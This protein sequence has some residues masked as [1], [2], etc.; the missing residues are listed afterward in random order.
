MG[1]SNREGRPTRRIRRNE[2]VTIQ[3]TPADPPSVLLP[4]AQTG[5]PIPYILGRQ[6]IFSPN[7]IWYGNLKPRYKITRETK[8]EEIEHG[9]WHLN[10][11]IIEIITI[12]TIVITKTV[13]GYTIDMQLGLCL[14]PDV[15][16][17][18]IYEDNKL[19][20]SGDV[21]PDPT[22]L[23]VLGTSFDEGEEEGEQ[24]PL[25]CTF[26]GGAFNQAPDP[27]L[28]TKITTGVPG[29]VG[30]AHFIV[31]NIDITKGVRNLSFE[32]ERH[33]DPLALTDS[34]NLIDRDLNVAS[35]LADILTNDWGGVGL[36]ISSLDQASFIEAAQTLA[37]E[38]NG[39]SIYMQTEAT[40]DEP[41]GVLQDQAD[42]VLY[43]NPETGK[44]VFKLI[45]STNYEDLTEPS[46]DKNNVREVRDFNKGSWVGVY[47]Q[48]RG[49]YTNRDGNYAPGA[50]VAQALTVETTLGKSKQSATIDYPAVMKNTLAAQLV[51]RDLSEY[52]VPLPTA[53]MEADRGASRL[54][55]G[56]G[57][58]INWPEHGLADFKAIVWKRRDTPR[59]SNRAVVEFDQ[60]IKPVTTAIFTPGDDGL[61]DPLDPNPH[62]P[63]S[64]R[65]ITA[66]TYVLRNSGISVN[67]SVAL[68]RGF[69]LVLAEAYGAPQK[70]FDGYIANMPGQ[71]KPVRVVTKGSYATVGQIMAPIDRFDGVTTGELATIDIEGVTRDAWLSDIGED[72][73]RSGRL[74]MW[75]NNE[76]LS[77]E[78]VE[79]LGAGVWRL[80]NVHRGL[81]DT[82]AQDH[83]T[84]DDV[85]IIGNNYDYLAKSNHVVPPSYTPSWRLVGNAVEKPGMIADSLISTAWAPDDRADLPARPHNFKINGQPRSA[86]PLNLNAIVSPD[87]E[88]TWATRNRASFAVALQLDA[89]EDGERTN[90]GIAQ[91][92]RL[93]LEDRLGVIFD[94]GVTENDDNYNAMEFVIPNDAAEGIGQM[95]VQAE[96][97]F[98]VSRY[99]DVL[100]V[101]IIHP[102]FNEVTEDDERIVT[103]DGDYIITD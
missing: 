5:I 95:W 88:A 27:Y 82:V 86:T 99:H 63:S 76:I 44:L 33:P 55:P 16:L 34:I 30:V 21:G 25:S 10:I 67:T 8:V 1:R 96:T 22:G 18:A 92:H 32:V 29:Y 71:A 26:S 93:M 56:D 103:E 49:T 9:Y 46:F 50:V 3:G 97:G 12:T 28:L 17:R 57:F 75:L 91:V 41:I 51:A 100:P 81:L 58:V 101:N 23:T 90:T 69:P 4:T 60:A 62:P 15:H 38:E 59:D 20:W 78:G 89:A 87:H 64:V 24:V 37:E 35:A 11:W 83:N 19:I 39:C 61:F 45:R 68:A 2:T 74:F 66:P 73:V 40:P 48:L 94:L 52:T 14:G 7:I 53:I 13:V 43:H 6:R 70:D 47:S 102:V 84:G 85:Y 54:L 42:G 36:D 77:F 65:F 98:G 31:K 79:D 72:G 80:S